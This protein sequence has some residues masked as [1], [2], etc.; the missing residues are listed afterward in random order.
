[1][2]DDPA[3]RM[4]AKVLNHGRFIVCIHHARLHE[5]VAGGV[6]SAGYKVD[7][8][9]IREDEQAVAGLDAALQSGEQNVVLLGAFDFARLGLDA[10]REL[11]RRGPVATRRG[12]R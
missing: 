9:Q 4:G 1:M 3:R 11:W 5:R 7:H 8:G 2:P 12:W 6:L 10:I